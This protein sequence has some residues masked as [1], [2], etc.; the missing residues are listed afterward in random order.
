MKRILFTLVAIVCSLSINAQQYYGRVNDKDGYV[1]IR[2]G[3]GTNYA[4]VRRYQSGEYLYYTPQNNG[5]SKVYSAKASSFYMG[6]MSTS[7]IMNVDPQSS[8]DAPPASEWL[9][10]KVTDPVDNYV[11]IRKGPGTKYAITGRLNV[12]ST[13]Y[14]KKTSAAWVKI[15]NSKKQY[16]GYMSKSRIK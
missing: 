1:N 7:R 10:G 13:V 2:K 3:P 14:Y 12:G 5:W 9:T 4:I 11:N 16:L 15:Y 6:F 8:V